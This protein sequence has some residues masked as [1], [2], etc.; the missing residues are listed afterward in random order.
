MLAV[1]PWKFHRLEGGDQDGEILGQAAG[2][3][4]ID[5]GGVHGKLQ[6][7]G[8]MGGNHRL[9][10]AALIEPHRLNAFDHGGDDG[11]A[12]GPALLVAVFDG[13]QQVV[14]HVVDAL[15]IERHG[16]GLSFRRMASLAWQAGSRQILIGRQR[17]AW[18]GMAGRGRYRSR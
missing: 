7:G 1:E 5:G 12:V 3:H 2:H 9:A 11:Q 18:R 13:G 4:R 10:R 14:R 15:C 17:V 8:R 16:D 6:A